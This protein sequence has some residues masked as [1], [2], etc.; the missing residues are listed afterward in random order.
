MHIIMVVENNGSHGSAGPIGPRCKM[1]SIMDING[2]LPLLSSVCLLFFYSGPP[3]RESFSP[4]I[5]G[6]MDISRPSS[7][8]QGMYNIY[9]C[10]CV[11]VCVCVYTG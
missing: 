1:S 4:L 11:C 6:V 9:V 5:P 3:S 7:D 8:L 10:V 2:I